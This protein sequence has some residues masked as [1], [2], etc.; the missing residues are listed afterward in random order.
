MSFPLF[1]FGA[2]NDEISFIIAFVIGIG[3]GFFLEKGGLGNASKLTAQFYFKDLSVF[4]VMFT[5]I[6]TAMIGVYFFA[7]FGWLDLSKIFYGDTYLL[8]QLVGGLILGAG[9]I[10]GGYCPGTS[11]VSFATG[12]I[13]AAVYILGVFFGIFVFGTIYPSIEEFYLSTNMGEVTLFNY[14]GISYGVLVFAVIV[15]ALLGFW[16]SEVLERKMNK[17]A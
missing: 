14:F 4:K 16:G 5:A 11:I 3:F 17:G 1:N 8:P 7:L 9:F 15:M 2:F 6:V 13:D 10:I 12:K